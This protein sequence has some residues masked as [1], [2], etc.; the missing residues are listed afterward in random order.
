MIPF[1]PTVWNVAVVLF[2]FIAGGTVKGVL[3]IGIPLVA[4]PLLVEIMPPATTISLLVIPILAANA[5]Q[6]LIEGGHLRE[7]TRR[8]WPAMVTLVV[9]STVGAHFLATA[10]PATALLVLG[11]IV[12]VFAA[13]QLLKLD[14]P[15]PGRAE[16]VLTPLVGLVAGVLGG[17]ATFFGPPI[18]LYLVT[19]R[20]PKDEFVGT[21]ALLYLIG[22]I[23]LF[24]VLA[25][26]DVLGWSEIAT[27]AVGTV[28]VFIGIVFGRWLRDRVS[29][30]AFRT[31]LLLFLVVMG[32]NLI[33]RGLF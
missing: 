12:V 6:G 28:V 25:V 19:L 3:G 32:I 18:I 16:R 13:S 17:I 33:R 15:E 8:F 5:W 31:G 27:S 2:A 11:L 26:R 29:Q 10:D 23:P 9:G 22:T 21:I 1:D 7:A 4:V 14:F 20:L 24:L 30:D